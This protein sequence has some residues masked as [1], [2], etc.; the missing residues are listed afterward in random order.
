MM[1][2][3]FA[4][5]L[6]L[7]SVGSTAQLSAAEGNFYTEAQVDAAITQVKAE[8]TR[9]EAGEAIEGLI[10]FEYSPNPYAA[11]SPEGLLREHLQEKINDFLASNLCIVGR[12]NIGLILNRNCRTALEQHLPGIKVGNPEIESGGGIKG[13]E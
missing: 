2:K 5:S 6:L 3:L 1:K 10:N 9:L 12:T 7:V 8:F 13:S 11:Y 4:T